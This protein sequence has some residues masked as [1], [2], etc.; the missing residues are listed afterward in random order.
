VIAYGH[1]GSLET[2]RVEQPHIGP[3]TGVFFPEQTPESMAD[4]ILRF[5]S[6]EDS[7]S[8]K[9]IQQHAQTFAIEEFVGRFGQFVDKVMSQEKLMA[10]S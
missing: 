10:C 9:A 2:V 7:F 3:D 5:E 1:G 4:G 6:R 8:A